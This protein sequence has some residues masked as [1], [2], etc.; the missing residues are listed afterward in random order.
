MESQIKADRKA[1]PRAGRARMEDLQ[2]AWSAWSRA[3]GQAQWKLST[4]RAFE[5]ND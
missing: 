3:R 4:W 2:D 1:M 5:G